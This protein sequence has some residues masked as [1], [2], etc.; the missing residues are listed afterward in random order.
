MS[1]MPWVVAGGKVGELGH[2]ERCGE[3]LSLGGPQRLE[4]ATAAMKAFVQA[5]S[6][7]KPG[8]SK[9]S[10]IKSAQEWIKGRDTGISSA[11]IWA[12]LSNAPTPYSCMDVPHD[13]ADFGR[14]YRLLKIVPEWRERLPE[15]AVRLPIWGPFVREWD[16][17]TEMYERELAK[18][19]NAYPMYHF[20]RQLHEEIRGAR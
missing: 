5:H 20:M 6:H 13:P 8:R 3:G 18:E 19:D 12:V 16:R 2:C 17:L 7:C 9:P 1:S 10:A 4:V 15:V 14:C 11:T